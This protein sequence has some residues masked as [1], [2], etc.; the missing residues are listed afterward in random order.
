VFPRGVGSWLG[1]RIGRR[2]AAR[3]VEIFFEPGVHFHCE[4]HFAA[5]RRQGEKL[6][7]ARFFSGQKDRFAVR[8]ECEAANGTIKL[9]G[10]DFGLA[11]IRPRELC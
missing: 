11:H 2:R 7:V 4:T 1:P 9:G 3:L 5:V 8:R 10:E 6:F